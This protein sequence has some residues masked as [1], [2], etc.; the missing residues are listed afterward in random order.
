M[1]SHHRYA[2]KYLI[3]NDV[4]RTIHHNICTHTKSSNLSQIE[5]LKKNRKHEIH[6]KGSN[7]QIECKLN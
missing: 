1:I 6:E 4:Q 2:V 7:V 3:M 5:Q